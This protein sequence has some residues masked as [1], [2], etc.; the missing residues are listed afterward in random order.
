MAMHHVV[1]ILSVCRVWH[2]NCCGVK[3]KGKKRGRKEGVYNWEGGGQRGLVSQVGLQ[4]R[5]QIILWPPALR[6][7]AENPNGDFSRLPVRS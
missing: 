5:A 7:V 4:N 1:L 3:R 6:T 2:F